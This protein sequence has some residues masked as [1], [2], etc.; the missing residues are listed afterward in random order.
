MQE[1]VNFSINSRVCTLKDA[2]DAG[3]ILDGHPEY[4]VP[5]Y[6]RPYEWAEEHVESFITSLF[7]SFTGDGKSSEPEFFGTIQ[8]SPGVQENQF[9]IID[10]QQRLTTMLLLLRVLKALFP[11]EGFL[12]AL[13]FD[14]LKTQVNNGKE[15]GDLDGILGADILSIKIDRQ[16]KTLD[17]Y[18][19]NTIFIK[20]LITKLFA[21]AEEESDEGSGAEE[22]ASRFVQYILGGVYFSVLRTDAPLAKTL[23]IFRAINTAGLPLKENDIFK[24]RFYEYLHDS[25]RQNE[26]V[27]KEIDLLYRKVE[28]NNAVCGY[29]E[30][31]MSEVL[32]IY[33]YILIAKY[34]LP[35][36]LYSSGTSNFYEQLFDTVA[37]IKT[38]DIFK[39]RTDGIILSINEIDN[40]IDL[41][42]RVQ[43]SS[44][45]TAGDA[46]TAY[47]IRVSRYAKFRILAVIFLFCFENQAESD[48]KNVALF[49][50]KLS[51]VYIIY[52]LKFSKTVKEI[53]S[54][55]YD[56]TGIMLSGDFETLMQALDKKILEA[57]EFYSELKDILQGD[58]TGNN[59]IKNL[60]LRLSAMLE[61][62]SES[63]LESD[64]S[65]IEQ[66]LLSNESDIIYLTEAFDSEGAVIENIWNMWGEKN[67]N[68]LGNMM[69]VEKTI[70]A[71]VKNLP[72]GK[73]SK[74]LEK[75][76]LQIAR[77]L[78][79][80]PDWNLNNCKQRKETESKKILDYLFSK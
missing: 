65:A 35:Q 33:K 60:L 17:R 80:L 66:K 32:E 22:I 25:L 10:G 62:N 13:D 7:Q 19:R 40:I 56:L 26:S 48:S 1:G 44:R 55:T 3:G 51:R 8:I 54:F 64:I 37:N 2:G 67:I 15:Q 45:F 41:R 39:N 38:H 53:K 49:L 29:E 27:F 46:C 59:A 9:Q 6:Q 47:F 76:S 79:S 78:P 71:E 30:S 31:N 74:L 20:D 14:W 50:R 21:R 75:S 58:I 70:K 42:Y 73:K 5:V 24:I 23:Q 69:L 77:K 52:S 18:T 63:E 12:D 61:E 72:F 34:K 36:S 28:D 43:K 16:N 4:I 68:S 57:K 11:K